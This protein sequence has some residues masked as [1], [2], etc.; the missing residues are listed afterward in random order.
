ME[1]SSSCRNLKLS[2]IGSGINDFQLFAFRWDAN[3]STF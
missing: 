3:I 2:Y 1:S